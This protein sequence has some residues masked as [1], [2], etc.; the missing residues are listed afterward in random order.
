MNKNFSI[1]GLSIVLFVLSTCLAN[2][3][4]VEKD[5]KNSKISNGIVSKV[6]HIPYFCQGIVKMINSYLFFRK[7]DSW[8]YF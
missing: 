1:L 2:A 3:E 4:N 8:N 5:R 6:R 7:Q